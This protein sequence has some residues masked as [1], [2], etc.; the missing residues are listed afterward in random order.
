MA[1]SEGPHLAALVRSIQ[2]NSPSEGVNDAMR[3][4]EP[5]IRQTAR[6]VSLYL[7]VCLQLE[8]DLVAGAP[9]IV[10][11]KI[12]NF[13]E[14]RGDFP[15]WVWTLLE[16]R[17]RDERK[18]VRRIEARMRRPSIDDD[19]DPVGAIEAKASVDP[20]SRLDREAEFGLPDLNVIE[21]WPVRD[22]LRM[23]AGAKLW[24]KLPTATWKPGYT[25]RGCRSLSL[26]VTSPSPRRR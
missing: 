2:S 18:R 3:N 19:P 4:L 25:R 14:S 13:D 6:R 11:E 9:S 16:N 17:L 15:G 12:Q 5:F 26:Q 7:R 1:E 22:R 20:V 24:R 8:N 10:W 23:L 21:G